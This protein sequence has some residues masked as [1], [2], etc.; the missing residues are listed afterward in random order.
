MRSV[1]VGLALALVATASADVNVEMAYWAPDRGTPYEWFEG[2]K[3]IETFFG[4]DYRAAGY[5]HAYVRNDGDTPVSPS[6]F[7]LDGRSLDELRDEYSVIWWRVLPDPIP[8]G[9]VG[10]VVVRLRDALDV[11]ATLSVAFGEQTVEAQITP[12]APPIRIETVGFTSAMDEAFVVVEALDQKPHR[13]RKVLLDGN[14]VTK[15][16]KLLDR[17]FGS[18]ISPIVVRSAQPLAEGSYHVYQVEL[19]DGTSVACCVRTYDGWVPLGSYGYSTYDEFA[20][21]GCNGHNNFGRFSK[22]QL[23][24]HET[25]LMRGVSIVGDSGPSDYMVGHPGLFGNCLQ[26]EPDVKDYTMKDVPAGKRVGYHA[27]EMERRCRTCREADPQKPTV[28]TLDM[29]YKPANWFIY[30]PIADV[31]NADCYTRVF[32]GDLKQVREVVET[33]RRGAGPHPLTYTFEGYNHVYDDPERMAEKRFPRPATAEEVRLSIYWGLGAGARG[34]Y[35]YIHCTE[36]WSGGTFIGSTDYP[37]VWREI[38]RSYRAVDVVAPLVALA[39]P[40]ELAT[41]SDENAWV[42]TLVCGEDALLI[43]VANDDYEEERMAFKYHPLQDVSISL[44]EL[45]WIDPT[46][47]WHVTESGIEELPMDGGTIEL[48]QLDVAELILVSADASLGDRLWDRH[49]ELE[50]DRAEALLREWRRKQDVDARR[51][52][53]RRRLDGEFEGRFVVGTPNSAYGV[54]SDHL[55]NP[56][57]AQHAGLEFGTNERGEAPDSGVNWVIRPEADGPHAIFVQ[58]GSW[59]QTGDLVLSAPDGTELL[60]QTVGSGFPCRAF[61][62]DADLALGGEYSL[63]FV[64]SGPGPKGGRVA[65]AIYVIPA[66]MNPPEAP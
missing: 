11:P 55:W 45:A 56:S 9:G 14:D 60:R 19:T 57:E 54:E 21:N 18:G 32:G 27:M 49:A 50:R 28:L 10:E 30:G 33:A 15:S 53:T 58:C 66:S 64:L 52:H 22:G 51:A 8:A 63:S 3:D 46:V 42:R 25:L 26:D 48:G 24:S 61:R 20:R 1:T 17:E 40:T 23:D 62:L 65:R 59:G 5:L 39:H 41:A 37:D 35:N 44:P 2:A 43:V 16:C 4:D 34:F 31:T 47:A 7:E 38:G 36:A 13:L 6:A 12:D 29:T